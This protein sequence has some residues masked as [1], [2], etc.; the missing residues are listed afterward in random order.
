MLLVSEGYKVLHEC[1]L[2]TV[3]GSRIF[4][5]LTELMYVSARLTWITVPFY[6]RINCSNLLG[7]VKKKD[8]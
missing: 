2:V 7:N 6:D 5:P 4:F 8:T 1:D 3:C